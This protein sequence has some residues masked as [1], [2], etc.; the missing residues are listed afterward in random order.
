MSKRNPEYDFAWCPGCGD[1][2][3][4]RALQVALENYSIEHEEPQANN[5]VVAGLDVPEIWFTLS[6]ETSHSVFMGFMV[7]LFRFPLV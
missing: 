3:V 2:G 6:K 1:F 4:R 5:I 7:V